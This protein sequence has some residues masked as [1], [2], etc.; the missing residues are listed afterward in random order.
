MLACMTKH[1]ESKR[2]V[3][4]IRLDPLLIESLDALAK[5]DD[6]SRSY[7]VETAVREY[8]ERNQPRRLPKA[9]R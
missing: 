8:V 4:T 6:R 9:S 5:R 3:V 2:P 7:I 1:S